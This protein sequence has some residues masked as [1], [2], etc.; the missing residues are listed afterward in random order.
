MSNIMPLIRNETIKMVKK[1]RLYIIFIVLAV[2][3]PMFTY[4]QMKSAE[5]NRDKFGGDWRLELQQAIT[6]NQNSLG[7]DRVPEEYKNIEPYISSRCSIILRM[8]S[9]PK[10]RAV[11]PLRG[12]S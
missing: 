6:D 11:S 8:T 9:I 12:S 7:S 5:N 2:L 3:V 10:N 4:A 1:K